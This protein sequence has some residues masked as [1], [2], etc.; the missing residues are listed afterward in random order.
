MCLCLSIYLTTK[1]FFDIQRHDI[2][3]GVTEVEGISNEES[4]NADTKSPASEVGM[5][6]I[7]KFII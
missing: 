1:L 6:D 2:V 3:N 5:D 7:L 4:E